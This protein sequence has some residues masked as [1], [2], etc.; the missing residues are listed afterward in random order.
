[1]AFGQKIFWGIT[2]PIIFLVL[3]DF[4]SALAFQQNATFLWGLI[5]AVFWALTCVI[6]IIK[7]FVMGLFIYPLS[8]LISSIPDPFLNEGFFTVFIDFI[9]LLLKS[10]FGFVIYLLS[11]G[12]IEGGN[13]F[14]SFVVFLVNLFIADP[15]REISSTATGITAYNL[16]IDWLADDKV[17]ISQSMFNLGEDWMIYL[18]S[19][20]QPPSELFWEFIIPEGSPLHAPNWDKYFIDCVL[21]GG[22]DTGE[23]RC[24][25]GDDNHEIC[26]PIIYPYGEYCWATKI[27][28]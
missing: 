25:I 7:L 28:G 27:I 10:L 21:V 15:T 16:G 6:G 26:F 12:I 19:N 20:I 23:E 18:L 22:F 13:F 24:I 1:M 2:F 4:I 3:L 8:L 9:W 17:I 14:F 11:Q 5:Q